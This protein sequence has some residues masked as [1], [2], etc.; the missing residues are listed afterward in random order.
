M[1]GTPTNMAEALRVM[2]TASGLAEPDRLVAAADR[3]DAASAA[4][5]A[6]EG[7]PPDDALL[8]YC[9]AL[10]VALR[11]SARGQAHVLA[12]NLKRGRAE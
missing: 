10:A 11:E 5:L 9:A 12:L 6:V 1:R 2:S 8:P 3:L 7:D 4:L